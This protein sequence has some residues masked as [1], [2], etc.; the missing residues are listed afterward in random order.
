MISVS[1]RFWTNDIAE[2]GQIQPKHAW[3]S[4]SVS[5]DANESHGIGKGSKKPFNSLLEIGSAIE[6]TL[7]EHG[8]VLYPSNRMKKY[9]HD[10]PTVRSKKK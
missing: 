10:R 8:I 3:T 5:I 6:E 1:V 9:V 4:G 2:D 7:L